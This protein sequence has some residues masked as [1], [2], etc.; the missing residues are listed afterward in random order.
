M[1]R[2]LQLSPTEFEHWTAQYFRTRGYKDVKRIGGSE[3]LRVD[4]SCKDQEGRLVVIQ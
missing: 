2:L 3:N 1:E 4:I